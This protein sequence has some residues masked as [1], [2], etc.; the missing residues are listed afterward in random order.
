MSHAYVLMTALPPTL[1][2]LDLI[3]FAGALNVRK[4]VVF[5]NTQPDEPMV[6]ERYQALWDTLVDLN[7]LE[8]REKYD[9]KWQN[10][11]TQQEPIDGD[12]D[13]FWANWVD[14]LHRYGFVDGDYIVASETYGVELA[15]RANGVFM[16]YDPERWSRYTKGT[17]VR[18]DWTGTEEWA[19]ILPAFRQKIQK[20]ITIFGAEST[21]K[22]TLTEA[23]Q[24]RWATESIKL[25]E[26]ARPYLEMTGPEVSV[27]GMY[28]IWEGQLALQLRAYEAAL[29]PL[30]IQDTDLYTTIGFWEHWDP[31][32]MPVGILFDA[33]MTQS[34]LYIITRSNIPFEHD[35][36]R[37]GGDERETP[38]QYWIDICEKYGLNYVVLDSESLDD[39]LDEASDLVF[40][41][42][43]N[44]I[45]YTRQGAEYESRAS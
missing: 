33:K 9:I 42:L 20:K 3:Q 38:D 17:A 24:S 21:G 19:S 30:V 6:T 8:G 45:E 2:H 37:Y 12:D 18:N 28:H 32:S 34:D 10:E 31:A 27:S 41:L 5:L 14:N 7:R 43:K 23:L 40:D 15:K 39:R 22:T 26:W 13:A 35:I 1:G 29:K 4:V 44:P 16:P 25:F 11:A 36:L